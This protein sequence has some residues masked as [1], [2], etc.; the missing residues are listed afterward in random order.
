M[1][2]YGVRHRRHLARAAVA[3]ALVVAVVV[4]VAARTAENATDVGAG[5]GPTTAPPGG[6]TPASAR[7]DRMHTGPILVL[8][9]SLTE[10]A[11]DNGLSK[12]LKADGWKPQIV[13]ETGRSTRGGIDAARRDVAS[14]P[15]LVIVE[16][17]TNPSSAVGTFA[18]EVDTLVD[19]LHTRGA[20]RI[21]WVTPVHH[22]DDRYDDKVDILLAKAKADPSVVVAD[23]RPVAWAHKAWFRADGLHYIDT[24]FANLAQFMTDAADANDPTPG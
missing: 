7:P 1:D 17:G 9:D 10:G 20:Q 16:L 18:E 3:V 12:L 4:L 6:V 5:A 8:G 23:W 21:V 19:L 2:V 13:A 24:G 22:D 15:P 11:D 14:A